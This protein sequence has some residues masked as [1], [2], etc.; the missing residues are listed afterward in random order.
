M[1]LSKPLQ[2]YATFQE[3]IQGQIWSEC[4]GGS[5]LLPPGKFAVC[6]RA[7]VIEP[8]TKVEM[9]VDISWRELFGNE[10]SE[11]FD[12]VIEGQN[13]AVDW[14]SLESLEPYSLE[15]A[16]GDMFVG[17]SAK[18]KAI[19]NK[20]LKHPMTSTYVTGQKRI[21]KTSLAKAGCLDASV[22]TTHN[23][24]IHHG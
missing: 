24:K 16:E 12:L 18:V 2:R 13:E 7:C 22:S 17:R 8:S 9:T 14:P 23:L 19:A 21:G 10:R 15:V 20:L 6:L 11:I 1:R 5:S 4:W 3:Y